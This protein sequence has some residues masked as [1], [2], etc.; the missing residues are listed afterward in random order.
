[1]LWNVTSFVHYCKFRKLCVKI[2]LSKLS[3]FKTHRKLNM[4]WKLFH[5]FSIFSI[6]FQQ[7]FDKEKND[8]ILLL[9]PSK[10]KTYFSFL[11]HSTSWKSPWGYTEGVWATTHY[12]LTNLDMSRSISFFFI[13]YMCV[14]FLMMILE[15]QTK[16]RFY[17]F[18]FQVVWLD[19]I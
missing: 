7:G 10:W 3:L 14:S 2:S 16:K 18:V 1:M 9:S 13:F 15:Q 4:I 17:N 6:L 5:R 11:R 12:H 8:E 19:N